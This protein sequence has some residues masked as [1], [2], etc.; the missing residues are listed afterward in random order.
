MTTLAPHIDPFLAVRP[1]LFGIAYRILG[2]TA[3]ADDVVQDTWIRWHRAERGKVRDATG[4]LVTVTTRLAINVSQSARRR[5]ETHAWLPEAVDERA[6]PAHGAERRGALEQ[7]VG[8]LL[9]KLSPAERAVL[10][11]RE[12]FDYPYRRAGQVLG[13]SEPN[14]RQVASRARRRL[15]GGPGVQVDAADHRRL[16]DAVVA[17]AQN[18]RLSALEQ[19]LADDMRGC[20]R[21]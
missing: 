6:D 18:G 19:L 2:D 17:A 16:L 12:G 5:R 21:A 7:A 20:C 11:L 4:F 3:E 13:L 1:R 10:I 14:T 9:E 15:A 8:T